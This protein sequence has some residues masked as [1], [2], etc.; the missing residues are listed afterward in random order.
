[1]DPLL[2]PLRDSP[3]SAVVLLLLPPRDSPESA[4]VPLLPPLR[5]E[6]TGVLLLL[7]PRV[8][9]NPA[10]RMVLLLRQV[11]DPLPPASAVEPLRLVDP[12][13]PASTVDPRLPGEVIRCRSRFRPLTLEVLCRLTRVR[14]PAQAQIEVEKPELVEVPEKEAQGPSVL[15]E[16]H[17]WKI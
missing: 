8:T 12:L 7:L 4:V 3:E 10:L 6:V 5:V 14:F 16:N 9:T 2:P 17:R 15:E 13:P 11:V 1:M